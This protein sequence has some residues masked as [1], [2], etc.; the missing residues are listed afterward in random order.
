MS[1]PNDAPGAA[2]TPKIVSQVTELIMET[3]FFERAKQFLLTKVH[4]DLEAA[5]RDRYQ[6]V[7]SVVV[8]VL[9]RMKK[10]LGALGIDLR[11]ISST[12][13]T[14]YQSTSLARYIPAERLFAAYQRVATRD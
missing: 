1:P 11:P 7:S 3:Q 12:I 5:V 14:W 8:P 9:D 6:A 13:T 10:L 4:I 2:S